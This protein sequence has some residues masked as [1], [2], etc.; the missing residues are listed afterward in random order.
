MFPFSYTHTHTHT[1]FHFCVIVPNSK[2]KK[3]LYEGTIFYNGKEFNIPRKW[4]GCARHK[5]L[6]LVD[7]FH[8]FVFRTILIYL[9]LFCI[10]IFFDEIQDEKEEKT[11]K[12]RRQNS[13]KEILYQIA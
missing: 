12:K 3:N 8:C 5:K 13:S 10:I 7:R 2:R 1:S 9:S 4:L 11:I 6:M